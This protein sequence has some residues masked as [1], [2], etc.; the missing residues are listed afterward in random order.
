MVTRQYWPAVGGVERVVENLGQAYIAR[1]HEVSV[2]AQCVDELRFG[3]MTHVVRERMIFAPFSHRGMPVVQFRPSRARR[4]WLLPLAAELIPFG[5]RLTRRW[6][7]TYST[8]YY[9]AVVDPVLRPLLRGADIVHML[10]SN[11]LAVAAVRSA[12]RLGAGV[13]ISPFAHVGEWGDDIGSI[14]A[15]LGADTLLA[16]TRADA[17]A[18]RSLG[19][20]EEHIEI[21]GL[22]VPDAVEGLSQRPREPPEG[23]RPPPSAPLVVFL[24]QRRPTKRF[25]LLLEAAPL[26]WE[27]HPDTHFAFVGPGSPLPA[28]RDARILDVGRVSDEMRAW[29]LTRADVLALPSVSESFGMVVAEAWSQA[30]PVLVSDI[31]VL[32][33]LVEES[34]GGLVSTPDRSSFAA[35][36]RTL[37]DN[38]DASRAMGRAGRDY[39]LSELT[40][41][42]V[43]DRHLAVYERVLAARPPSTSS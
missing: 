9:A 7:G 32:R 10:G 8:E 20:P 26:V 15:Y 2:V 24:G 38:P 13:V 25:E 11:F 27:H 34:G 28:G 39:W 40:P 43:A 30:V 22:P 19:V 14:G 31:P 37:L 23:C 36:I 42:A 4:A 12:H 17:D 33:E 6:L 5:G 35:A 3:R 41:D 16:T 1:G 21:V 18:Y 29:W